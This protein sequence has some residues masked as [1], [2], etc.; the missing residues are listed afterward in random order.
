MGCLLELVLEYWLVQA[1]VCWLEPA[2][3]SQEP[4]LHSDPVLSLAHWS[5]L[6]FSLKLARWW[7]DCHRLNH[8]THRRS[9]WS[10]SL[11][12]TGLAGRLDR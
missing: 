6:G 1:L 4:G 11:Q 12:A 10:Q 9:H 2:Y 3:L 7:V 8:Q 5:G